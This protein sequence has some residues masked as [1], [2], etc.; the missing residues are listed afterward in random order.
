MPC[1]SFFDQDP[2]RIGNIVSVIPVSFHFHGNQID[3]GD[4]PNLQSIVIKPAI[5]AGYFRQRI[6]VRDRCDKICVHPVPGKII[7]I[8][9]LV[10]HVFDPGSS[11]ENH[12]KV[13]CGIPE[14]IIQHDASAAYND[15]LRRRLSKC[16]SVFF[17]KAPYEIHGICPG[18]LFF[19]RHR[20]DLL[21]RYCILRIHRYI[22]SDQ[23]QQ[24]RNRRHNRVS[25]AGFAVH[26]CIYHTAGYRF[27]C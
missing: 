26:C 24:K 25:Q 23:H 22:C 5:K 13:L 9:K 8:R 1:F 21:H 18:D 3:P 19:R 7:L 2:D 11:P 4:R 12:I 27:F 17:G 10:D 16:L 20:T 6:R 14:F 15:N